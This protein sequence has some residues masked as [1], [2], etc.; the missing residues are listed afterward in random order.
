MVRPFLQDLL[1]TVIYSDYLGIEMEDIMWNMKTNALLRY[2]DIRKL[3]ITSV[4][5]TAFMLA[6]YMYA[7]TNSLLLFDAAWLYRGAEHVN[8][9]SDKWALSFLGLLDAHVNEPWLAG[10]WTVLFMIVSVYFIVDILEIESVWGICLAAGLCSTQSSIVCQQGY[11]GGQYTGEAALAF[12]CLAAW[13]F[14]KTNI[15]AVWKAI[16]AAM[17]IAVSAGIYGAYVSMVPS[18]MILSIIMDIIY[19]GKKA[20]ETWRKAMLS[21]GQFLFGM[22]LYYVILRTGLH[23]TGSQLQSYMG[24]DSLSS[25]Q[26]VID[27]HNYIAEAYESII[28][29]YL[30]R[31]PVHYLPGSLEKMGL[32][33]LAAGVCVSIITFFRYKKKITDFKYNLVLLLGLV[34]V[35]PL[36]LNLIYVFASGAVHYLMIFTYVLP[37]IFFVKL[38]EMEI[39]NQERYMAGYLLS[40]LYKIAV[41]VFVYYSVVM[42]NATFV[43]LNHLYVTTQSFGTRL[44]GRIE[45]CEGF[46][47][48]ETIHLVGDIRYNEYFSIP[49]QEVEILDANL[50]G[51]RFAMSNGF[52]FAFLRNILNSRLNYDHCGSVEAFVG[53]LTEEGVEEDIIKQIENMPAFPYDGSVQKID[54]DIYVILTTDEMKQSYNEKY[55]L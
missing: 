19:K 17:C 52:D 24:E 43:Q 7:Y 16:L 31:V 1:F 33:S 47:G 36:S 22:I 28:R 45:S 48:T 4:S 44:L 12:A 15:R 14:L 46:E 25:V 40:V 3:K 42:A 37:Y 5:T 13:I 34:S 38:T 30:G 50:G 8:F 51:S 55:G 39:C 2:L 23:F 6:A 10:I 26:Q 29:Y 9:S 49:I 27:K 21:A 35:L 18:L 11:I 54:G 41:C 32:A 20:K 53:E